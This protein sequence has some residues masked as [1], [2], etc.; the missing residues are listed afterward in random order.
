MRHTLQERNS[1]GTFM[2]LA[3]GQ[4]HDDGFALTFTDQ[5]QFAAPATP[6]ASKF[7]VGAPFL[8]PMA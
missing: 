4:R 2:A 1:F 8:A 7:P 3:F 5:V 6:T